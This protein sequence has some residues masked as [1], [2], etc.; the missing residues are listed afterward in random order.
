VR[1]DQRAVIEVSFE[2]RLEFPIELLV[3]HHRGDL[4]VERGR[5]VV[6]RALRVGTMA[7][8]AEFER[9]ATETTVVHFMIA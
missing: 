6:E 3:V 1:I 5:T 9:Q 4:K 7:S 2:H 8:S